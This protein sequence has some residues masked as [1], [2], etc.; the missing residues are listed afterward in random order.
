[1]CERG[2]GGSLPSAY[3]PQGVLFTYLSAHREDGLPGESDKNTHDSDPSYEKDKEFPSLEEK[4]RKPPQGSG[5][6]VSITFIFTDLKH[7]RK[8]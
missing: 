1:M 2:A 3:L 5:L 7:R 6:W 8:L 4:A